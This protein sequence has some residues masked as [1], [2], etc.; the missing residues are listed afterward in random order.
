MASRR[1]WAFMPPASIAA[2]R[3]QTCSIWRSSCPIAADRSP[4][5]SRPIG[6]SA[7][8]V[9]LDRLHLRPGSGGPFIVNSGNANAC[10]GAR[11]WLRR[12]RCDGRGTSIRHSHSPSLRGFDR[13]H[14]SRAARR[15]RHQGASPLGRALS[16][17]GGLSAARAILTTDLQTESRRATSAHR[18]PD[19]VT[20]GGMAKGSGMIHPDMATMLAYLTTDAAITRT[21]LQRALT[22]GSR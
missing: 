13:S 17:R 18:R 20:I 11:A 8:P 6:S 9:L 15:S 1:R 16:S 2:S 22:S 10:T 14:R 19:V 12:K 21:A 7:A 5:C 3:K 4:A